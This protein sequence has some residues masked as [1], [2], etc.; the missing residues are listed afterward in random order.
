[1][2][3]TK[4][5]P[6]S[7][8]KHKGYFWVLVALESVLTRPVPFSRPNLVRDR[9]RLWPAKWH[10]PRSPAVTD[11]FRWSPV[12]PVDTSDK[13]WRS[14]CTFNRRNLQSV[15]KQWHSLRFRTVTPTKVSWR[16]SSR[17]TTTALYYSTHNL[18][19]CV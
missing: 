10:L 18:A 6:F 7:S 11:T 5:V 3:L 12:T 4:N 8:R 16:P 2:Y 13:N 19:N 9:D 15:A 14:P 1:M 17:V